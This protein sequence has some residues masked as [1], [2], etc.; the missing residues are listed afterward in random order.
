MTSRAGKNF[1]GGGILSAVAY[2][3]LAYAGPREGFYQL[4]FLFGLAFSGYVLLLRARPGL[5]QGLALALGLR[6]LFLPALPQ[7]SDDFYRFIWDGA[8]VVAG[9]N[10][11]L[12]LPSSLLAAGPAI[13]G[14]SQALFTNLNS[15]N[16]YSVY[17]PL[18]QAVFGLARLVAGDSW[19]LGCVLMRLVLLTAEGGTIWLLVKILKN[20]HLPASRAWLYA[21][22]PLV[23][24][25]LTGN[26]HFEALMIFFLVA[27]LYLLLQGFRA[28]SA[29]ALGLSIGVKLLP[30]MLL[31]LLLAYLGWKRFLLYGSLVAA[32]LVLLFLPFLSQELLAHFGTSIN[33]YFQ[34]F[35]FNASTYYLLRWLGYQITGYNMIA[36]IGPCLSLLTTGFIVY[37][38]WLQP[39]SGGALVENM[40]LAFSVYLLL[41]TVVHPWYLSTLVMLCCLS[42][43]RYPL[44]WSALALLSYAAYQTPVYQENLWL[45][46]L[47]YLLVF[48]VLALEIR[49]RHQKKPLEAV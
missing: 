45:I 13:P 5:R 44:A 12:A 23:I 40:L 4:L 30:L 35:E 10:P 18:C 11:Y 9:E 17:P 16:Y 38:A 15:P 7:L 20:W 8:L 48:G 2:A 19:L 37:R 3:L 34:K 43:W 39:R 6:L 24:V 22:N 25:E 28:W 31:P 32:V 14:I 49:E 21:F 41:A 46:G 33:L 26:L 29:V 27:S 1:Y 47:E 36:Q 42:T